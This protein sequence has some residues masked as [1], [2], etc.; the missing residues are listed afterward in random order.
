MRELVLSTPSLL[1][2]LLTPDIIL[3]VPNVLVLP[4]FLPL[5]LL[6][7]PVLL[8]IHVQLSVQPLIHLP[9]PQTFVFYV[10]A[11]QWSEKGEGEGEG[12][13]EVA[14]ERKR[15]GGGVVSLRSHHH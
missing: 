7:H 12:E 14:E 9:L 3:S 11:S 15:R 1:S 2:S 6:L 5:A 4:P 10:L 13:G 8:S